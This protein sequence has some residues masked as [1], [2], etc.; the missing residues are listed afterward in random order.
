MGLR[1][2]S[3]EWGR[4]KRVFVPASSA[5]VAAGGCD[6]PSGWEVLAAEPA[7]DACGLGIAFGCAATICERMSAKDPGAGGSLTCIRW[8]ASVEAWPGNMLSSSYAI[9]VVDSE[10]L[11]FWP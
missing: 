8:G 9:I 2:E 6:G 11:A 7:L 5:A 4:F 1:A 3:A 10:L